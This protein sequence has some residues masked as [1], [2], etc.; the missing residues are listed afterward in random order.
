MESCR[1]GSGAD[2]SACCAP[3]LRGQEEAPTAEAL[4]RSR[5]SA[6]C[7]ED[8]TYLLRTWHPL[9]R[10]KTLSFEG[11]KTRWLR[12]EIIDAPLPLE[13]ESLAT[14][15]FKAHY[16]SKGRLGCLHERSTF[17]LEAEQI[18][19]RDGHRYAIAEVKVGM[20][21]PCP[22]GSQKKYKRCCRR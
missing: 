6:F 13:G 11:E 15:E 14:V 8:A 10:P 3:Y 20:N 22:C 7:Y 16:L 4:M 9:T 17:T 19:Y 1:C 18:L 2:H 5:F 21:Q 12:L